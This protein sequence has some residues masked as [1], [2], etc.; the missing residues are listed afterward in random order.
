[1]DIVL[2]LYHTKETVN[3]FQNKGESIC[4]FHKRKYNSYNVILVVL[5][6]REH[7]VEG[8]VTRGSKTKT[9]PTV[10]VTLLFCPFSNLPRCSLVL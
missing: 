4:Y 2:P 7:R 10:S 6:L 3:E 8:L 9:T 5:V 1:M